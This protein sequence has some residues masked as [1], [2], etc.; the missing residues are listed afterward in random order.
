MQAKLIQKLKHIKRT[1]TQVTIATFEPKP[2]VF[3]VKLVIRFGLQTAKVAIRTSQAAI[4]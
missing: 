3:G 2:M 4:Q 1:A